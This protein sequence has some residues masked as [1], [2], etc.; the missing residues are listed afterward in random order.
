MG[1]RRLDEAW[2]EYARVV[3]VNLQRL[4]IESGKS[5]EQLAHMAGISAYTYQKFEKGE[6]RPGAPLNPRITTLLALCQALDATLA[7]VLPADV[8]DLLAGN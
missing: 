5:Q 4:R 8:P 1:S 2:V 6:S 7:D 3:G